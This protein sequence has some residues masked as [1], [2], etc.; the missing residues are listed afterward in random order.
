MKAT[1]EFDPVAA[2]LTLSESELKQMKRSEL[3]GKKVLILEGI[4]DSHIAFPCVAEVRGDS[5]THYEFITDASDVKDVRVWESG[6]ARKVTFMSFRFE[7]FPEEG[8]MIQSGDYYMNDAEGKYSDNWKACTLF[9]PAVSKIF[10]RRV[11]ARSG[12]AINVK[13]IETKK[14]EPKV[15]QPLYKDMVLIGKDIWEVRYA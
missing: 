4:M 10:Y 6:L 1:I 14:E 13:P 15:P 9:Q 5:E 12:Q 2:D 11:V 3:T 8:D 7:Y